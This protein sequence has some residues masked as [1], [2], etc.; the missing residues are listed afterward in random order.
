MAVSIC[1]LGTGPSWRV[2]QAGSADVAVAE[3]DV[4]GTT[5]QLVIWPAASLR[6]AVSAVDR[7]L[8]TLDLAVSRFRP[9][10]EL[11]RIVEGGGCQAD[12]SAALAEAVGIALA[13]ARWTG[14]LVDPTV[15]NALV[16]LGYD[17]DFAQLSSL[18]WAG[19]P[20][21]PA[22][23]PGW[24]S[25]RLTGS[26]LRLP[27]GVRLDLGATGKGLGADRAAS[28]ALRAA[29][30][31]GVLVSLGGD[32]AVAGQAPQAG[33]PVLVADEH[34][35]SA[36]SSSR[37]SSPTQ[38]VRLCGGGL[39]TS[40]TTCRQWRRAGHVLH[41]IVDPRTGLP[42][43]G[44]WRTASV[45]AATGAEA[46]AAATAAIISGTDAADWLARQGLPARLVSRDGTVLRLCGW[47]A[48]DH[49]QLTVPPPRMPS[50]PADLE[51]STGAL[52]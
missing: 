51:H 12:V 44:P 33:W 15:G 20:P 23:V 45:A 41:H 36:R 25:V 11:S 46:N 5:A 19:G 47:P 8:L 50:W 17:R 27:A 49:G 22:A 9:D 6:R 34:D 31:G 3:R 1:A 32:M 52:P 29:V 43:T 48:A 26:L 39:A 21:E 16:E 35:Q 42:A 24:R 7:E 18:R 37:R 38:V 40:S 14:G 28:A 2:V 4:L 10:S 30:A 13:A